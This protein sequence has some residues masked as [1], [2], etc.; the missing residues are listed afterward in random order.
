MTRL[1]GDPKPIE[2]LL[3]QIGSR[4]GTLQIVGIDGG[5]GAGKT[6]LSRRLQDASPRVR[7]VHMDD[8]YRPSP[9]DS[10]VRSEPCWF[11]DWRRI[12]DE[13]LAPLKRGETARFRPYDWE[14]QRLSD[15][16]I[17][18]ES[19]GIVIVEGIS[20]LR[21]ELRPWIDIGLWVE[22]PADVRLERGVERD[23]E[24]AR[25]TWVEFWMA[26]EAR[27]FEAHEPHRF[28]Q[29]LIYGRSTHDTEQDAPRVRILDRLP[30]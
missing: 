21:R 18:V 16:Q 4:S 5:G 11:F 24:E 20:A 6:T 13:V 9:D 17:A 19:E 2:W 23:G 12:R 15:D 30:T 22:T 25:D 8:F 7:C 14:A 3:D 26:E 28:A 10:E 1:P 29:V 27:Y